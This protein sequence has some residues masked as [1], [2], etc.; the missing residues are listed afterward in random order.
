LAKR[1]RGTGRTATTRD[2]ARPGTFKPAARSGGARQP[3]RPGGQPAS[4][5]DLAVD[6][7]DD[8]ANSRPSSAASDLRR[9]GR[10]SPGRGPAPRPS[11]LLAARA[12]TEYVYVAQDV[13]R[14]V[15]VGLLLFAIMLVLWI[16]IVVARVITV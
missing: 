1:T 5:L 4:Q 16:L 2:T 7:A 3:T 8:V 10:A 14:I 15:A 11:S 6:A 13:R 12:A 9:A